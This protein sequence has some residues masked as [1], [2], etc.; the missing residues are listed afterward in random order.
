MAKRD[1]VN[2]VRGMVQVASLPSIYLK[3]EDAVN[4]V[5]TTSQ[6]IAA[7]VSE[8]TAL[9]ARLLR[10]AN[11]AMYNFPSKIDTVTQAITIIGTV[12]PSASAG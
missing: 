11:S 5:N 7:I 2:L 3:V 9:A 1:P 12:F 6:A 4:S 10:L 8:D